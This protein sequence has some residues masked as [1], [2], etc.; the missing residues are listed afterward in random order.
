MSLQIRSNFVKTK[1]ITKQSRVFQILN[2][3]RIMFSINVFEN[4]SNDVEIVKK[5]NIDDLLSNVVKFF[6]FFLCIEN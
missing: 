1:T 2:F 3:F 4:F 6:S 5:F